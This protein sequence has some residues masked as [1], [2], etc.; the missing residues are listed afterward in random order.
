MNSLWKKFIIAVIFAI[1]L[2]YISMGHMLGAPIPIFI[3]PD[4][5][6]YFWTYTINISH[7]DFVCR[8]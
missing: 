3:N 2:L 8:I 5:I 4:I 7:S 1:P 6:R